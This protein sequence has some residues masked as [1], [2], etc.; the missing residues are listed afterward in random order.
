[1]DIRRTTPTTGPA[2][3]R[4]PADRPDRDTQTEALLRRL[5][6]HAEG[7]AECRIALE[8]RLPPHVLDALVPGR[9]LPAALGRPVADR[10]AAG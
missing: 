8:G 5:V 3:D 7:L 10:T 9:A 4:E 6:S 1:M 2:A